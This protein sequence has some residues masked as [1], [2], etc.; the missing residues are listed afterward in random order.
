MIPASVPMMPKP[1]A[2]RGPDYGGKYP[3]GDEMSG[4]A[5]GVPMF[6]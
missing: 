1:L 3:V 5:R 4:V 6:G 2:P